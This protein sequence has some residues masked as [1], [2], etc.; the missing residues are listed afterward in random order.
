MFGGR[1]TVRLFNLNGTC[2]FN[3]DFDTKESKQIEHKAYSWD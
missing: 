1:W 3:I 2:Y